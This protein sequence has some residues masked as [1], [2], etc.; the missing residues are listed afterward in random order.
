MMLKI[1]SALQ[2]LVLTRL[3]WGATVQ[4]TVKEVVSMGINNTVT[5]PSAPVTSCIPPMPASI[6][7]FAASS[8]VMSA[9]PASGDISTGSS[10]SSN[11]SQLG[12]IIG[13]SIGGGVALAGFVIITLILR[14]TSER[15]GWV[16]DSTNQHDTESGHGSYGVG[17]TNHPEAPPPTNLGKQR[18]TDTEGEGDMYMLQQLGYKSNYSGDDGNQYTSNANCHVQ[19][20]R[21]PDIPSEPSSM[22]S[23]TRMGP[24]PN[25]RLRSASNRS[26]R[27]SEESANIDINALAKEVAKILM[28]PPPPS[29]LGG[30][31]IEE[32]WREHQLMKGDKRRSIDNPECTKS[33]AHPEGISGGSSSENISRDTH[34]TAPPLYRSHQSLC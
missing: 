6:I 10:I 28:Q 27:E 18:A 16:G 15:L 32:D 33:D 11:D 24:R 13:G 30:N 7:R 4:V 21:N 25:P 29:S 8:P 22:P 31:T 17:R 2:I 23:R 3:T 12:P 5:I 20:S 34:S 26:R 9:A 14:K 19:S 1:M